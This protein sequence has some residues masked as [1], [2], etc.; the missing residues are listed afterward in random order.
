[1]NFAQRWRVLPMTTTTLCSIQYTNEFECRSTLAVCG[2]VR[3]VVK[4][5]SVC[6]NRCAV[7]ARVTGCV[8]SVE[9]PSNNWE[10]DVC[11]QNA[12]LCE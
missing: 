3:R 11:C 9:A 7:T 1:M 8:D 4:A 10:N 5:I 12:I 6:T 2:V